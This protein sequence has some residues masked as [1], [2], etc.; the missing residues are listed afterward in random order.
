MYG[1][2]TPKTVAAYY[3]IVTKL[4]L[5]K[6]GRP[7]HDPKRLF[8]PDVGGDQV[9]QGLIPHVRGDSFT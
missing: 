7:Q 5:L 4:C 3:Y 6:A 9:M 2:V 8:P 1:S